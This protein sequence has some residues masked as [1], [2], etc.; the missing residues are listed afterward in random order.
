MCGLAGFFNPHHNLP[1]NTQE[2]LDRM[3]QVLN[4][5]GPDD[6]GTFSSSS[7]GLAFRRLSIID[8]EGGHQPMVSACGRYTIVF[9]GEIYNYKE[10]G[11]EL[12]KKGQRFQSNSD[13]EVLLAGFK[14]W[15]RDVVNRIRGMFAFAIYD[16]DKNE[17]F[18]ARDH[19]GI[20]PLYFTQH[21]GTLVFASEVKSILQ[22]PGIKAE[23]NMTALPQYLS[24]LWT[25]APNTLFKDIQILEPGH[26]LL[27]SQASQIK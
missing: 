1:E 17:I 11:E 6:D 4:H 9:N 2:T 21:A 3:G 14:T 16:K 20:K 12:S 7:C 26:C 8:V 15:G 19:Y 25:P 22:F 5:R 18:L 24:F 13:T 23:I 27:A 10:L